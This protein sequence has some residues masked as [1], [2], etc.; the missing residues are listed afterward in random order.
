MPVVDN[1]P[2]AG[3]PDAERADPDR[4]EAQMPL[5]DNPPAAGKPD[6]ERAEPALQARPAPVD[7]WAVVAK[8]AAAREEPAPQ[9]RPAR[10]EVAPREAQADPVASSPPGNGW[11]LSAR[12]LIRKR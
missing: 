6:A 7:N 5:V 2:A 11:S 9:A 12:C 4:Q 8:S 1:P 3:K 10:A